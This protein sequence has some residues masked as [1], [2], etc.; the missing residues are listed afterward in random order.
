MNQLMGTV[1]YPQRYDGLA[2]H[3]HTHFWSLICKIEKLTLKAVNLVNCYNCFSLVN[4]Y[5]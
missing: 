2:V 4:P 3:R 5:D 1:T